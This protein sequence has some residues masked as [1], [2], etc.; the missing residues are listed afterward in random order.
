[1]YSHS[2]YL[3]YVYKLDSWLLFCS[4]TTTLGAVRVDIDLVASDTLII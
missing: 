1:M 4:N 2:G 3:L